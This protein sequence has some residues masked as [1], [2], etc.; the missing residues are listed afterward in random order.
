MEG[1]YKQAQLVKDINNSDG[2]LLDQLFAKLCEASL[3]GVYF[4]DLV[5]AY[6]Q[7][8]DLEANAS[9]IAEIKQMGKQHEA[10]KNDLKDAQAKLGSMCS[11]KFAELS[12]A[13]CGDDKL[14]SAYLAGEYQLAVSLGGVI[15]FLEKLSYVA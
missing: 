6:G 9:L 11:D 15:P 2:M 14:M 1:I 10:L 3:K 4:I 5:I 12:A 13:I 8:E 7:T